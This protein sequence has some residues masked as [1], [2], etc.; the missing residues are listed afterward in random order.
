MNNAEVDFQ[1]YKL[2][3]SDEVLSRFGSRYFGKAEVRKKLYFWAL[4]NAIGPLFRHNL[5]FSA[6]QLRCANDV[7]PEAALADPVADLEVWDE[8]RTGLRRFPYPGL[9]TR[10][11][12]SNQEHKTSAASSVGV[13]GEILAGLLTQ[14]FI[15]PLVTVR[16]IRHWPDFILLTKDGRYAFV[17]SKASA[18]PDTPTM[19]GI[20]GISQELLGEGLADTVQELNAD[21]S[22]CVWLAFTHVISVQPLIVKVTMLETEAPTTRQKLAPMRVPD[23]VLEGLAARVLDLSAAELEPEMPELFSELG[24]PTSRE[25]GRRFYEQTQRLALKKAEQV[26]RPEVPD[27]LF[28]EALKV[29]R[30]RIRDWKPRRIHLEVN[31]G[32]RLITA[33]QTAASGRLTSLRYTE[34][35]DQRL[36]L[37]DLTGELLQELTAQWAPDWSN[38]N[39]PWGRINNIDLWRCSSAVLALG[40][41]FLEGRSLRES[42]RS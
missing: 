27:K 35:T 40:T 12:I 32:R 14:S 10:L 7:F 8:W 6:P 39:R 22:L 33:K 2:L 17:E 16:P 30:D 28:A 19:Q 3:F 26:I 23:A 29:I 13:L 21:P 20:K 37:A 41:E 15:T 18:E 5:V 36:F 9:Y 4:K 31:E 25:T 42:R 1:H 38:A 11:G 24:G 34:G